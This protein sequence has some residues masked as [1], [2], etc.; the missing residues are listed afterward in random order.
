MTLCPDNLKELESF[1]KKE[2]HDDPKGKLAQSS[3]ENH[4]NQ[5]EKGSGIRRCRLI[6]GSRLN[7]I[8]NREL[9]ESPS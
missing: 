3:P 2:D 5:R 4:L 9:T 7:C 6:N 8:I 1:E